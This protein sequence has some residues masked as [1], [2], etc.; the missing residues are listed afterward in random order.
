MSGA[1]YN[2]ALDR[3]QAI[4]DAKVPFSQI[5][6]ST[7]KSFFKDIVGVTQPR[8]LYRLRS[9]SCNYASVQVLAN[10]THPCFP[11]VLEATEKGVLFSI[12]V[13]PNYELYSELL[14]FGR[15]LEVISPKAVIAAMKEL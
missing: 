8:A 11:K 2:L 14:R 15:S 10:Q 6:Y 12:L 7:R 9:F 4:Q 3:I 13:V 5:P 1:I